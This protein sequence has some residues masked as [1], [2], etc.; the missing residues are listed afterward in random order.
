MRT[1]FENLSLFLCCCHQNAASMHTAR[2][3]VNLYAL[4]KIDLY[5]DRHSGE[6]DTPEQESDPFPPIHSP[7]SSNALLGTVSQIPRPDMA[8]PAHRLRATGWR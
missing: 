1:L 8:E 7:V 4:P 3:Q 6:Q 2:Q 5:Q